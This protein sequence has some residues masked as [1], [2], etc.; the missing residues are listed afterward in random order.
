VELEQNKSLSTRIAERLRS[1]IGGVAYIGEGMSTLDPFGHSGRHT[2]IEPGA[3]MEQAWQKVGDVM[4]HV[5]NEADKVM[6]G[7]IDG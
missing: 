7:K 4:R 3:A 2:P 1:Y 5:M 6:K